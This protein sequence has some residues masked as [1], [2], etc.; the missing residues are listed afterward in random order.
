MARIMKLPRVFQLRQLAA[1]VTAVV[2]ATIAAVPTAAASTAAATSPAAGGARGQA[3]PPAARMLDY[4]ALGDSYSSGVGT[5][6]YDPASGDCARS[7][8]SYPPL[9]ASEH[10]PTTFRFVACSGATTG[11][12]R[13]SQITALDPA[14]DLVTITI[15][16]ND[17]GFGSVLRTCTVAASDNVCIAAVD[18]AEHF[19]RS[20]LP[21][22]LTRTYAAIRAAAPRAEV[23]VLGY[24]RLFDLAPACGD[25]LA[26]NLTRRAKLNEGADV[27][28]GVIYKTV[29]GQPGF[30]FVDVRNRFDGHGVCSVEP[31]INGPSAPTFVGPYHPTQ[32]G[33]REGYLAALDAT[34]AGDVAAA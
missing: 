13:G 4:V 11:D 7:P 25:P 16:G 32:Q 23:I 24:P 26:P 1:L 33:Y 14:T 19:A 22:R 29:V 15:G 28:D 30:R 9:W 17:A 2:G 8:L 34:S 27:I 6:V 21:G 10:H 31:W 18:A 20:E 3:P 12:V 5:G